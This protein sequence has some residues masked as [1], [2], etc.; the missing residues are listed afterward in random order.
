M[1]IYGTITAGQIPQIKEECVKYL[2]SLSKYESLSKKTL[3]SYREWLNPF[4]N[5]ACERLKVL[6]LKETGEEYIKELINKNRDLTYVNNI[7]RILEKLFSYKLPSVTSRDTSD[8][9][10]TNE[11]LV[12]QDDRLMKIIKWAE[13][14]E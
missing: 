6:E 12:L 4:L 13:T 9:I 8:D 11:E 14:N 7:K 1:N 2:E 3:S 10:R 5:F